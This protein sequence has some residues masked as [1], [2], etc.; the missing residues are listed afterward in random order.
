MKVIWVKKKAALVLITFGEAGMFYCGAVI[1]LTLLTCFLS[2]IENTFKMNGF[3]HNFPLFIFISGFFAVTA[4][5]VATLCKAIFSSK[6]FIEVFDKDCD[7]DCEESVAG[8]SG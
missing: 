4:F 8:Q 6:R 1:L 5:V 7:K 2:F 3:L